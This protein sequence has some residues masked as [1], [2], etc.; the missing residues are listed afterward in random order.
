MADRRQVNPVAELIQS[1]VVL[2]ERREIWEWAA[3]H[4]DFGNRYAF[5][6]KFDIENVPWTRDIYRAWRNPRVRECTA[7]MPPQESGKTVCAEVCLAH[8]IA[9]RPGNM[10]F[11]QKTNKKGEHWQETRWAQVLKSCPSVRKKLSTDPHK[12]KKGKIIFADG[13]WLLAQGAE[14][15]A[16]RQGDSVE[17]EFNDECHLWERPWLDQMHSRCLAYEDTC[18]KLNISIGADE[19]GELHERFQAGNQNEWN[20]HCPKCQK[21]FRYVFNQKDPLCNI[22]FDLNKV[23]QRKDGTLDLREFRKTVHVVCPREKCGHRIEY[24]RPL[25]KRLNKGGVYI[26]ENP[27]ADPSIVSFHVNAFAIGRRHWADILEPWVRMSI[28]GGV[29][30]SAILRKFI[31]EPLAEFWKERP[32]MVS[33]DI[34]LGSYLRKDMLKPKAWKEEWIRLFSMDNQRGGKGDIPHRW[35]ACRAFSKPDAAGRFRS[36]LVDCG[37]LNEWAECRAKQVELG[38]PDWSMTRPGPW[39]VSDRRHDPVSV[40][41]QCAR[42]KWFGLLGSDR[43]EFMHGPDSPHSGKLMLFTEPREIDIGFGTANSGRQKAVYFLYSTNKIQD[44]YEALRNGKN[45]EMDL[46]ADLMEFCPEYAEHVNSHRSVIE[47]DRRGQEKRTWKRIGGW[48]DHLRD[49]EIQ[50]TLLAV[51][52]GICRIETE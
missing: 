12:N 23:I 47:K 52:A 44:I 51:M 30:A 19:G 5:K 20:H 37:R 32:V 46:P 39:V 43:D 40:D 24:S 3:E 27:D 14:T 7:V 35:F 49:C 11:N 10:A 28:Q 8:T 50:L 13:T 22:R 38:V 34:K 15:D 45:E 2:P 36:R 1:S 31:T 33:K 6:G 17:Y 18:K 42:H 48:P 25:L 4:I 29:F 16:N 21:P 9:N 26:P 41:E